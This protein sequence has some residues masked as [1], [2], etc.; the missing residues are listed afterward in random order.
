M[1]WRFPIVV[2]VKRR[3]LD[4]LLPTEAGAVP[5]GRFATAGL[6]VFAPRRPEPGDIVGEHDPIF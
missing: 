3:R 4:A 5:E 1:E 6:D 2:R